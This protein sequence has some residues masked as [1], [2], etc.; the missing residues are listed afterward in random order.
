[1][2]SRNKTISLLFSILIL[3]PFIL[4]YAPLQT[5]T[6]RAWVAHW[7][8]QNSLDYFKNN[9][10]DKIDELNLFFYCLDKDG[11]VVNAIVEEEEYVQVIKSLR[12]L[13]TDISVTITNDVIYSKTVRTLKDPDIIHRIL[14]DEVLRKRHIQQI[15]NIANGINA[16]GVDINYEKIYIEDK[17]KFSQFIKELSFVLHSQNKALSVTV[18][19]KTKDHQRSGPGA[20]DWKEISGYADQIIIM[21]YNYSSKASKPGPNCP[22]FWLGEIIKFAK[23]QIAS[24][25]ICIALGLYGYDWSD[26]SVNSVNFSKVVDLL[27]QYPAVLKWDN[28]SQTPYFKYSQGSVQH[29]VWFENQRS[30]AKKI[31]LI[32]KYDIDHIAIWHLGIMDASLFE[33]IESFLE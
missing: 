17:N 8:A 10:P 30:I 15:T 25:K 19:Q 26:E 31:E 29:E 5:K 32:K 9:F 22:P 18:H 3:L 27:K 13:K 4:G 23:S 7:D 24:E 20:I 28:K 14:N 21:C 12:D 11:N 6:I 16:A 2:R 33:P 1:M